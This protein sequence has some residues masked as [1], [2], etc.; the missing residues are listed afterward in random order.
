MDFNLRNVKSL[1]GEIIEMYKI[2]RGIDRVNAQSFSQD[3]GVKN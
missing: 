1:W 2:T 3:Q